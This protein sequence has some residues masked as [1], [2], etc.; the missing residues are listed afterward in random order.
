MLWRQCRGIGPHCTLRGKS[1][2]FSRVAA[3]TWGSFYSYDGD[4]PKELVFV[5]QRLNSC[6]VARETSGFSSRLGRAIGTPLEVRRE[7]Q[8][9]F[10]VDTRILGFLSN[11]KGSQASSPFEALNSAF[12]FS[13]QRHLRPPVE[14]RWGTKFFPRAS[15]GDSDIPSCCEMKDVP[16]FKSVQGN[17]DLFRVRAPQGPFHFRHQTLGPSRIP[18]AERSL[19]LRCDW[20]VGMPLEVKERNQPSS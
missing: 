7:T 5:Q 3:G 8:R 6:L 14:M 2:G 15:T 1:H 4:G 18:L 17:Q 19:L 20:K 10:P 12:L 11:F 16:A 13:C 9:P